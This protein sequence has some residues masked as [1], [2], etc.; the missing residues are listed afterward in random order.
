[1]EDKS[2]DE[3]ENE[4]E[5]LRQQVKALT[6]SSRE[7][8]ALLSLKHGMTHRLAIILSILVTRSPAL[9]SRDTL[10]QLLFGD[11]IDGG[12][13]PRIFN[14]YITRLRD[15]L[16]R[17]GAKGKI[18]TVWNAGFKASPELVAWV[19]KLYRKQIPQEK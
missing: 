1:M 15:I 17:V 3:L 13:D 10:H 19:N 12:P 2:R 9:I 7:I 18:E 16:K 8:G 5:L 11:R 4:L 14:V 6:G